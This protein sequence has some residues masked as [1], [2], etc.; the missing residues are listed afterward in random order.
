MIDIFIYL[1]IRL[2]IFFNAVAHGA[3]HFTPFYHFTCTWQGGTVV[4]YRA[5]ADLSDAGK[6][7][8]QFRHAAYKTVCGLAALG[9]RVVIPSHCVRSIR[10][11][12]Q[13]L[14]DNILRG[15]RSLEALAAVT[16]VKTIVWVL[17][18]TLY[19]DLFFK[20]VIFLM[21]PRYLFYSKP[22]FQ[23]FFFFGPI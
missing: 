17:C 23:C 7:T 15:F 12:F 9:H 20:P 8:R 13:I 11:W 5:E 6:D 16:L 2:K 4:T 1:F 21:Q 10:Q 14:T 19:K 3:M 22:V 18:N